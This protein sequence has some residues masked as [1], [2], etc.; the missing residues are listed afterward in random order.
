MPCAAERQPLH[1]RPVQLY[2]ASTTL[3]VTVDAWGVYLY[4][5]YVGYGAKSDTVYV[6]PV[7]GGQ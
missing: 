5:G 7:R 2:W 3:A 1:R 6:W 4:D